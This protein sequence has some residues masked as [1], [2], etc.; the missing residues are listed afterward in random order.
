VD[1][2]DGGGCDDHIKGH[3]IYE[4]WRVEVVLMFANM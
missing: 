2:D 3:C 1:I 4:G